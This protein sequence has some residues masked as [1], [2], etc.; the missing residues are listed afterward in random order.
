MRRVCFVCPIRLTNLEPGEQND[1]G[2]RIEPHHQHHDG[3][4]E[5]HREDEKVVVPPNTAD[6]D[7][8]SADLA[9]RRARDWESNNNLRLF[10]HFSPL[11]N[12]L[13]V[14]G[15]HSATPKNYTSIIAR[16]QGKSQ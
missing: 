2:R 14:W 6:H 5:P 16:K 9:R 11:K 1:T 3:E 12:R 7:G 8:P 4:D 15:P 10:S 13:I